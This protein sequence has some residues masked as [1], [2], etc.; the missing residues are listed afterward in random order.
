MKLNR[1]IRIVELLPIVLL[2]AGLLLFPVSMMNRDFSRIPGDKGD[3]RFNN[4]ILEH[5][6]KY[7]KGEVPDYWD[8]PFLYP[9]RNTIALSDNL[10][11]TLPVYIFLDH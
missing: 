7:A 11:G 3:A 1:D 5:G 6:Y 10:L 2:F 4:Y 9:H 8:A